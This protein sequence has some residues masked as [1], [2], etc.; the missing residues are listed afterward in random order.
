[1][2]DLRRDLNELNT[3]GT[4]GPANTGRSEHDGDSETSAELPTLP[5]VP[6]PLHQ[7]I[8]GDKPTSESDPQTQPATIPPLPPEHFWDTF[9]GRTV[10]YLVLCA[11]ATVLLVTGVYDLRLERRVDKRLETGPF[12]GT[13]GVYA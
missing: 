10:A 2:P 6:R 12:S 4:S 9:R 13:I 8:F 1:M 7:E 3:G 11:I 5:P